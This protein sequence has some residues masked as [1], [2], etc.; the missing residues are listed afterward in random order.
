MFLCSF[1][2]SV[3]IAFAP[4][5]LYAMNNKLS[6]VIEFPEGQENSIRLIET[7]DRNGKP[8][9]ACTGT[10]VSDSVVLTA[11]HCVVDAYKLLA[12][13]IF[14]DRKTGTRATGFH[15]FCDSSSLSLCND[16]ILIS[17]PK[18]TY[19]GP[20]WSLALFLSPSIKL[21]TAYGY[22]TFDENA[23]KWDGKLRMSKGRVSIDENEISNIDSF[24]VQSGDSGGPLINS[25]GQIIGVF[26]YFSSFGRESWAKLALSDTS[27]ERYF[28]LQ[29]TLTLA[30]QFG[31]D[32][33]KCT[34]DEVRFERRKR[35]F[36]NEWYNSEISRSQVT[37]ELP[38]TSTR[39][40]CLV[41]QQDSFYK[42]EYVRTESCY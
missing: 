12:A 30:R 40:S 42:N 25:D 32:R 37:Y 23:S 24:G 17:F 7:L 34:C 2:T 26:S 15:D 19:Q 27:K 41:L 8:R 20:I 9:G 5:I 21:V 22:G 35:W 14:I 16:I 36:A 4:S 11:K 3:F 33:T 29:Y 18:G 10:F 39:A 31:L 13:P 6:T 28:E 1:F 38:F